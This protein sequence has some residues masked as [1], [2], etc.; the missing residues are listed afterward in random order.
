MATW[1]W[2]T[3]VVSC[4]GVSC[5]VVSRV[6]IADAVDDQHTEGI[7]AWHEHEHEHG[8]A[9]TQGNGDSVV[10]DSPVTRHEARAYPTTLR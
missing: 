3:V 6:V 1:I 7:A 2:T 9:A 10:H 4:R 8:D 5:V